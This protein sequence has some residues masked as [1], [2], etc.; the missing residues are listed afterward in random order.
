MA[1]QRFIHPDIWTDPAIGKLAP[2]ERL[3]FIGCFSNADDAGR[4][5]GD[6]AYLRSTIFPY[7]DMKLGDVRAMRD[8][9][10]SI[11]RNLL[12]YEVNGTAYLA[13]RHW[14]RYQNPRYPKESK[15][16]PPPDNP[17]T[18]APQPCS[19][20]DAS[21]QEVGHCGLGRVGLGRV[22]KHMLDADASSDSVACSKPP[23]YPSD[24]VA[25]WNAYP[26]KTEKR[27]AL[28]AWRARL[29][30]RLESGEAITPN[31]LITAGRCYAA[32]CATKHVE[33]QYI[34]H[35]ASFLSRDHV[36]AEYLAVKQSA[37]PAPAESPH[38]AK[39]REM[40]ELQRWLARG[41]QQP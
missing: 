35:P 34:K 16:P 38:L 20:T 21:L 30:E 28:K 41:E 14:K 19:E 9:V 40:A 6:P 17:A 36:F 37:T 27:R 23:E 32:H 15:L 26:R 39:Q 33:P 7:D 29:K 8:R 25:F 4:L 10:V 24:F 12:I 1:R 3:L 18:I 11:C 2:A 22:E 13:F 31:T 5:L